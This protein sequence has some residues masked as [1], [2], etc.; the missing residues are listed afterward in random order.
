MDVV[1]AEDF[2]PQI[3]GAHLWLYEAYQRWPTPVKLLTRR[4]DRSPEELQAEIEFDR[5]AHGSAAIT[6]RDITVG[7]ID[8]LK[9]SC[10]QRF[11]RVA[12]EIHALAD[13]RPVTIH[14]LR[15][16]PEGFAGLIAKLRN[17]FRTRL[18]T[19]AHGEEILVAKS[20]RQLRQMAAAVYRFSDVVIANSQSTEGLVR[21]LAATANIVSVHP[22]VD[23]NAY[24]R[25]QGEIERYRRQWDWPEETVVVTTIARM[26]LR[27]NQAAILRAIASL[28]REG[29][30]LGYVCGGDG[31]EKQNLASLAR[32]LGLDCWV[33]FPGRVT[34]DQ[35]ILIF[36]ASDIH[37]M[38]S[39][40]VGEMIEG[41]G[42][43]FLEAGAAGIPSIA[44]NVG[45]QAEAVLDGKT[46]L[47]V[48]GTNPRQV[49]EA[50][51]KLASDAPLRR[52]MGQ[53]ARSWAQQHD[54][55][56]VSAAIQSA[57][58]AVTSKHLGNTE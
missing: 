16:F 14:C 18:I 37:A 38:P 45:G 11:R 15:A 53:E 35:K 41:F 52:Q 58:K 19:F 21:E 28:R 3:G 9:S 17:P 51:R 57:V 49:S 34:D 24:R 39:I 10:R 47:V 2:F 48:D 55:E 33:R 56:V 50:I 1:L 26:E 5:R 42:I 40:R 29:L 46:G 13:R 30:Q 32:E 12:S 36:G 25:D 27:K 20:S 4:Y 8:L 6:R 44:G 23:V 43:V 54:W 31:E 7:E 22:G